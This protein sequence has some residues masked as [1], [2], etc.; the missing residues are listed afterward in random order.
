MGLDPMTHRPRTDFFAALPQLI[1]LAVLREQ[2]AADPA[3]AAA[4]VQP[5]DGVDVAIQAAKLQYLQCI[6]QS[7]ATTIASTAGSCPAAD[8]DETALGAISS[9]HGTPPLGGTV[10][11]LSAAGAQVSCTTTFEEP[12]GS[13]LANQ[14]LSLRYGAADDVLA[15]HDNNGSL[16]PLTDLSDATANPGDGCSATASS[17]FGDGCASSPLPWP[18]FFPDDPFIT[19]FL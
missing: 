7:A 6:L 16:P 9:L 8:A 18:E 19:D 1:A 17:S 3:A 11:M 13:E 5:G 4:K 12:M 10:P 2:L 15:C 14:G